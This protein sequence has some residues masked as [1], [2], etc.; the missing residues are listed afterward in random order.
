ME[1]NHGN[2]KTRGKTPGILEL[3]NN[4]LARAKSADYIV[5][6]EC[7]ADFLMIRPIERAVHASMVKSGNN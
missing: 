2:K 1:R 4:L 3:I 6:V 5:S 7:P